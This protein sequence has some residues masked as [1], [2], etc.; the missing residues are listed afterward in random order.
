MSTVI[1]PTPATVE[2]APIAPKL[3]KEATEFILAHVATGPVM[4]A[5]YR[6]EGM[7]E[8]KYTNKKTGAA[9]KFTKHALALEYGDGDSVVQMSADID[10]L[11]DQTPTA[12]G[13]A[14]GQKLILVLSGM[15]KT[16]DGITGS[17]AKHR[18]LSPS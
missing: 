11:K 16:R 10:Y 15:L 1:N 9:E 2:P 14:R 4:L 12:T 3:S 13:Y 8:I 17:I 6:G 7:E 18:A 5:E